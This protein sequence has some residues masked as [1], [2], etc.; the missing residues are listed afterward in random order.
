METKLFKIV[1]ADEFSKWPAGRYLSDSNASG[2]RFRNELLIP[3]LKELMEYN[4]AN[5]N[6][7]RLYVDFNGVKM[8]GGSWLEEA[9]GGAVRE[10]NI[11]P[12]DLFHL[13]E[14]IDHVSGNTISEKAHEYINDEIERCKGRES[15]G[16]S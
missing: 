4:K 5:E 12:Y 2:E 7:E 14:I 1:V 13:I 11:R 9:F 10:S 3:K 16:N 6:K 15:G 8:A